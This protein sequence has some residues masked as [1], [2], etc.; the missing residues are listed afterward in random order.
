MKAK[1]LSKELIKNY[2]KIIFKAELEARLL[3][4]YRK[5]YEIILKPLKVSKLRIHLIAQ[6]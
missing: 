4:P 5:C 3:F 2:E 1:R 6:N